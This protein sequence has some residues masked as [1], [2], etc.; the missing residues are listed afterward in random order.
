MA[1]HVDV[2]VLCQ[3]NGCKRLSAASSIY[4]GY[5]N[6]Q[7]RIAAITEVLLVMSE[8]CVQDWTGEKDLAGALQAVIP[9]LPYAKWVVTTLGS[10]GAVLL[11]RPHGQEPPAAL[12]G[13]ASLGEVIADLQERSRRAPDQRPQEPA[14]TSANGVAIGCVM[15]ARFCL[16]TPITRCSKL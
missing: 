8:G 3:C 12:S 2:G 5:R 11:Q 7:Q 6:Q 1:Q 14:C 10:K 9:V 16:I 15:H 4:T 13:A